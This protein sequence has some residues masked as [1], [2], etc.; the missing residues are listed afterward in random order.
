MDFFQRQDNARRLTRY[1][2]LLFAAA[3]I[4]ILLAVNLVAAMVF[5]GPQNGAGFPGR[6]L[7][8]FTQQPGPVLAVTAGTLALIFFA[9]VF[10]RRAHGRA[11]RAPRALHR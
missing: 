7:F 6:V 10:L 1:L 4:G 5:G 2:V 3:V 11:P 8:W 9:S